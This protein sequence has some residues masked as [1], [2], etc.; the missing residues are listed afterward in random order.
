LVNVFLIPST[1]RARVDSTQLTAWLARVS[2]PTHNLSAIHR[3][4]TV[5]LLRGHKAKTPLLGL[6]VGHP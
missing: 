2:H 5:V 3:R 1:S 6:P 4:V